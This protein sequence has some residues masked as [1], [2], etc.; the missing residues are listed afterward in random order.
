MRKLLYTLLLLP[1]LLIGQVAQHNQFPSMRPMHILDDKLTDISFAFGMRILESDYNGALI[2]LRRDSDDTEMDF[3]CDAEDK[4][5]VEA[6]DTWRGT[7]RVYVVIW[8]DQ[9]GL[10]RNAVQPV[11]SRQPE[12]FTDAA[13]PYFKGNGTTHQLDVN[14]SIQILT[15]AGANGSILGIFSATRKSQHSFGTLVGSNRW[16]A[17]INWSNGNLYFDPGYCC[18]NPR[19]F[20]NKAGE[21]KWRQYTLIRGTSTVA[22]RQN[23]VTRF[24]GNHTKGRCTVNN[25]FGILYATGNGGSGS[26]YSTIKISEMIMYSTDVASTLY[27]A[28]E[29]NQINFWN[30]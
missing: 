11:L 1:V 26:G 2:R 29:E 8:Y 17:H 23:G 16:S 10:G 22:A 15:N 5:D 18:N 25:N 28:V 21:N 30:L 6:I 9:S 4:V 3:Y 12:F 13:Q 7:A 27:S 24:S 19:N 20:N 14:T